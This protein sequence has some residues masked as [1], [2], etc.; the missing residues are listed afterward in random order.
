MKLSLRTGDTTGLKDDMV[1]EAS[2]V[3]EEK[4]MQRCYRSS[5]GCCWLLTLLT[6]RLI[7]MYDCSRLP[8][9]CTLFYSVEFLSPSQSE[10]RQLPTWIPALTRQDRKFI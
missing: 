10:P 4:T 1:N 7:K 3:T 8:F 2:D 6:S 5:N 9:T